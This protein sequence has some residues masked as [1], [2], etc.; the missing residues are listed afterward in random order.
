MTKPFYSRYGWTQGIDFYCNC[1]KS[2]YDAF[3]MRIDK[4]FARGLG[5]TAN[6]T[7]GRANRT[8][9]TRTTFLYNRPLGYGGQGF[10]VHQTALI[11]VNY[12]LRLARK[13]LWFQYQAGPLDM[14]LGGWALNAV[15]HYLW[16]TP[17]YALVRCP[18]GSN[19]SQPRSGKPSGYWQQ[20]SLRRCFEEPRS[21]VCRRPRR[22]VPAARQ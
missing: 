8:P 2:K 12:D 1:A 3:Q 6:Y 19:S 7:Y 11:A 10:P 22:G 16:R 5:V 9:A 21:M 4:R 13:A 20:G 15:S 14:A 17:V 18:G